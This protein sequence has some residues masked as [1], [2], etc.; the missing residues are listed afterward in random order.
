[1]SEDTQLVNE[2]PKVQHQGTWLQSQ[3]SF[4]GVAATSDPFVVVQVRVVAMSAK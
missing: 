4:P 1:M 2:D 3:V